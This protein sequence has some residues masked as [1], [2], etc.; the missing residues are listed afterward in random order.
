[1][2]TVLGESHK[3][4]RIKLSSA[5]IILLAVRQTDLGTTSK[6]SV[7]ASKSHKMSYHVMTGEKGLKRNEVKGTEAT[8]TYISHI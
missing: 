4:Q 7:C 2:V 8:P 1:V 3:S 5:N 6:L